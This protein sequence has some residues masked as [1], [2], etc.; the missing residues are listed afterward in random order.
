MSTKH[1]VL[2]SIDQE[3]YK[4]KSWILDQIITY[5]KKYNIENNS[6]LRILDWGCGRGRAVFTL[7]QDGFEAYGTDIDRSALKNGSEL[8]KKNGYK[9]EHHLLIVEAT[10]QWEP[11]S[12]DIIISDQVFEHIKDLDELIIQQNRLLKKN[13]ISVHVFPSSKIVIEPHIKVP[14]V[15]WLPKNKARKAAIILFCLL[16]SKINKINWPETEGKSLWEKADI[17]YKYLNEKTYYRDNEKIKS[18]FND[19]GFKASYFIKGAGKG[20]RKFIPAYFS[21]NGFPDQQARFIATKI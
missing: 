16:S 9:P 14:L 18:T 7:L 5:K 2:N 13:G 8:F 6:D 20:K 3:S 21:R 15:H 17:Y 19:N 10:S 12:F 4:I 1:N 11:E